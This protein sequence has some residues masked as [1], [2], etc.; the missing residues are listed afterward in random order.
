MVLNS[1]STLPVFFRAQIF[2]VHHKELTGMIFSANV[3][4]Q[5]ECLS[6]TAHVVLL[7]WPR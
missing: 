2:D 7:K 5:A 6:Q 1:S 4:L 3:I